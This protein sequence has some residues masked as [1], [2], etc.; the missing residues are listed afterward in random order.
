MLLGRQLRYA[1]MLLCSFTAVAAAI[2]GAAK[3]HPAVAGKGCPS[4]HAAVQTH[5]VLHSP[6]KEGLCETC[7]VVPAGGGTASFTDT[8]DK[9]CLSCHDKQKF[10]AA[11]VHGPVAVGACV[12]CHDP[13][14]SDAP[15]LVRTAGPALCLTCHTDMG[16]KLAGAKF[17]H[18]VLEEGCTG[19][20]DPHASQQR[21]QL[22]SAVPGLCASCHSKVADLAAKAPVK[23]AAMSD[24]KACL[25]CHD[26]HLAE[27]G[28]C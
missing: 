8:P 4:C 14:G 11:F 22:R 16:A 25:N 3:E 18:K 1:A 19:C 17:R 28:T 15:H 5:R 24:A 2:F 21:F 20:H 12:A 13:H 9:L 23:H 27:R 6:A 10:T 26:P 7:H